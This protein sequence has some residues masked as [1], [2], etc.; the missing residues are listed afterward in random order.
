VPLR[1]LSDLLE[2]WLACWPHSLWL[3]PL[4]LLCRFILDR[5][6]ERRLQRVRVPGNEL[7][8]HPDVVPHAADEHAL[9]ALIPRFVVRVL[10]NLL[11]VF[12]SQYPE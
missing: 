10:L 12:G 5:G 8:R 6:R 4:P 1:L 2:R 7:D 3:V 9:N 11:R